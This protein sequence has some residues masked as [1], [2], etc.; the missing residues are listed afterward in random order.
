MKPKRSV[1]SF[2]LLPDASSREEK[3][4]KSVVL[5]ERES[6]APKAEQDESKSKPTLAVLKNGQSFLKE[7]L[8]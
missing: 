1:N 7:N 4:I 2:Q 3:E 5:K 6:N 8:I